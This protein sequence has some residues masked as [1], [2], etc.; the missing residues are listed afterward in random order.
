MEPVFDCGILTAFRKVFE[1]RSLFFSRT[2]L[3]VREVI[4]L[5]LIFE[6][7]HQSCGDSAGVRISALG[8]AAGMSKPAVSQLL[9]ILEKKDM[10]LRASDQKDKRAILIRLSQLGSAR[11]EQAAKSC[12]TMIDWIAEQ[13]GPED[14][15]EFRRLFYQICFILCEKDSQAI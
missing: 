9:K 15:S 2:D 6:L 8:T 12:Q 13:L 7:N 1:M 3:T 10:I 4:F 5:N 11:L 14:I